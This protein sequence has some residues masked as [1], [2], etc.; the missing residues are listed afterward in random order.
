M[1][2]T[3]VYSLLGFDSVDLVLFFSAGRVEFSPAQDVYRHPDRLRRPKAV[4]TKIYDFYALSVVLLK[5][6]EW[7]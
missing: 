5:I 3:T 1:H 4:F 6:R 2:L 7:L